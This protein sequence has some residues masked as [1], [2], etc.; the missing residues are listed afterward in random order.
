MLT[1][2]TIFH[3]GSVWTREMPPDL[4]KCLSL[5]THSIPEAEGFHDG[6]YQADSTTHGDWRR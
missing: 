1:L 6:N 4:G 2:T 3:S 5:N